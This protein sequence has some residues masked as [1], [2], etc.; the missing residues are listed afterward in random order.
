MGDEEALAG[1][2]LED[3]ALVAAAVVVVGQGSVDPAL[4]GDL[5][6]ADSIFEGVGE[7]LL[8]VGGEGCRGGGSARGVERWEPQLVEALLVAEV[9]EDGEEDEDG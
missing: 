9:E 1:A 8:E 3:E 6:V 7:D 5:E 2:E 4:A